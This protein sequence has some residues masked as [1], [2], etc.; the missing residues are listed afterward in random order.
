[1]TWIWVIGI[2]FGLFV[3]FFVPELNYQIQNR[4]M[5]KAGREIMR[6]WNYLPPSDRP[7]DMK[8]TIKEMDKAFQSMAVN[9]HFTSGVYEDTGF[10]WTGRACS[11]VECDFM[12]YVTLYNET[13]KL[14]NAHE[15]RNKRINMSK[16]DLDDRI[17]RLRQETNIIEST[18]KEFL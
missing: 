7:F 9:N 4:R 10:S 1:M 14:Y 12:D 8:A 18:T 5:S 11:H 2:I 6:W 17:E 16:V 13:R 15:K 3:T